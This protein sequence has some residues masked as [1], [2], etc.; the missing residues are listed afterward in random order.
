ML[1]GTGAGCV[2]RRLQRKSMFYTI[3]KL[4]WP[5]AQ[6]SNL[7]LLLL[8]LAGLLA[9]RTQRVLARRFLA[10]VILALAV[11]GLLPVGQWLLVPLENRFPPPADLPARIDGVVM[12]GGIVEP[13]ITAARGAVAL[14]D[15]AERV[16]HADR[17]GAALSRRP[18]GGQWRR[19]AGERSR[20]AATVLARPA[21]AVP[22]HPVRGS[23]PQHLRERRLQPQV[24]PAQ[25][26][27]ALAAG[28]LGRA[29]A[30]GGRLLRAAR[31]AGDRL[32]GRLFGRPAA[33][34]WARLDVA[35]RLR[36][37]DEA[38]RAWVGGVVYWLTGRIGAP[39]PAP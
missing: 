13:R 4:L 37:L 7:L 8:L 23:G 5:L 14:S 15:P 24:G 21:T 12:L 39:F 20:D 3:S 33:S 29:H 34:R 17:A 11:C 32:P 9:L 35:P 38:V 30:A 18:S 25:S 36:E 22:A 6:P 31:L 16:D 2:A 27:R 28:D 26:G 1:W 19:A 10:G